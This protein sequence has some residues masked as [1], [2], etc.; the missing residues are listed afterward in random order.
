MRAAAAPVDR[1][2]SP[3]AGNM[4]RGIQKASA[5]WLGRLF[6]AAIL[7][8]IAISFAIWGIGDIFRGFG[9]STVAK[10]GH[11]EISVEQFRQ[12]YTEQLQQLGR[13]LRRPISQDQARALGLDRQ[14]L[15]QMLA[16]AALDERARQLRLAVSDEEIAR[17]ITTDPTFQGLTGRF[18][19]D[20]FEQLIRSAGFTEQRYV[21]EQRRV[22]LRRHLAETLTAGLNVPKTAVEAVYRYQ[23][24]Q[25]AVEYVKLGREQAG[26]VPPP[27]PEAVAK[28]FEE[29][30][31]LFRAP[32]YRKVVVLTLSPAEL[33][34]SIEVSDADVKRA[35]E[36]RRSSYVT[37]E[38][39]HVQQIVFPNADE[40]R[41]AAERIAKDGVSFAWLAAERGLKEPDIDLGLVPKSGIVDRA[42]AD[43]A[44]TLK[45]GEVSAPV[46][47]RFGNALVHVV[48]VEPEV[49]K[50]FEEVAADLKQQLAT[51][52]AKAEVLKLHD[53]LEDE[54]AGGSNLAE[55]AEKMKL[56]V[57]TF[58]VD[59]SGRGPD[60][61]PVAGIP[62]AETVLTRAFASDVGV[63]NDPVQTS[64]GGYLWYD[65][66]GITPARERQLDEVKD[67]V[68][69]RLREEEIAARLRAKANEIIEQ[70]KAGSDFAEIVKTYGLKVEK[71]EGLKRGN[72]P[73]AIPAKVNEEVFRAKPGEAVSVD[74][75]KPGERYVFRV[76]DVK[77]P[78]LDPASAEAKQIEAGLRRAYT[79]EIFNQYVA[80]LGVEL[81]VTINQAALN[82]VVGGGTTN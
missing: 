18:D 10:I 53:K 33:A 42:I 67:Q 50:S 7:G 64:D 11:T 21:A 56:P 15:G 47:G 74:G 62:E 46:E 5:N 69:A 32:E 49:T 82:Q 73:E 38:R 36:E 51:E 52:R 75:D 1:R 80:Q 19:R 48:K 27:T 24:E 26:D 72:A 63:E 25:R 58:E 60:G 3:Q 29:R 34:K 37:P 61:K 14:I 4:L 65:V 20:R 66:A 2:I 23:Q 78:Q 31:A 6:M 22:M 44:F 57:R 59:R 68:E 81:G 13:Q 54:R 35:Y 16:E 41:A 43:A 70:L 9:R 8:V 55:I 40:A 77:E 30:K 17:K 39:R 76:T 71:A 45:P 79:E 12:Y 28:Y